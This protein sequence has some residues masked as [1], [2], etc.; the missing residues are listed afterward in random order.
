MRES[1]ERF[2]N[3]ADNAPVMIW[4]TGPDKRF[5]FVNKAWLEFTGRTMDQEL[6]TGWAVGLHPDDHQRCYETFSSAFDA[7]RSFH[8]ECR[9]RRKDGEYRTILCRGIPRFAP[10]GNFA[11]YI[12]S[13][14]DITEL[15]SEERFRQLAENIHEVFWMTDPQT[16]QLLYISPAYEQVWGRSCQSLYEQPR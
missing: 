16:T 2:R 7:R 10:G 6:G 3:M 11:G 9:L 1:E 13:D 14:I 15:Q 4:V 5:T 12:G 8:L